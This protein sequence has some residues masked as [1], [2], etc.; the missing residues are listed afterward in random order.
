[1]S[2]IILHIFFLFREDRGCNVR[3]PYHLFRMD[4]FTAILFACLSCFNDL[5][6]SN[7][8]RVRAW[9]VYVI[10]RGWKH[11]SYPVLLLHRV[12]RM[13]IALCLFCMVILEKG[14]IY[15]E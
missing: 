15:L 13:Q 12:V 11:G 2:I 3:P 7:V 8:R 6:C 9:V 1:M 14:T 10:Y 4:F 5:P